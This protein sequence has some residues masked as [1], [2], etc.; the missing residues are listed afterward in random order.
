MSGSAI[1]H[2]SEVAA[3]AKAANV[4][5]LMLDFEPRTSEIPWIMAYAK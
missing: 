4:S 1:A 5:G 3:F 2:V